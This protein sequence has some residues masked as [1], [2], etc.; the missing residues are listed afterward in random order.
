MLPLPLPFCSHTP[1]YVTQ[2]NFARN[3]QSHFPFSAKSLCS[4]CFYYW[5]KLLVTFCWVTFTFTNFRCFFCT[6]QIRSGRICYNGHI[7]F[8]HMDVVE[9]CDVG[10]DGNSPWQYNMCNY[11]CKV[12]LIMMWWKLECTILKCFHIVVFY[13]EC[14][15]FINEEILKPMACLCLLSC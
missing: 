9:N 15:A 8:W 4:F 6:L 5:L 14:I 10:C 13:F 12:N 3:S 7:Q 1:K 11:W 2:A